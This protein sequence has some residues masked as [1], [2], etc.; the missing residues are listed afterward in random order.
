MVWKV[1]LFEDTRGE[2]PVFDFIKSLSKISIAKVTHMIDL[3]E[4]HGNLV[5]MPHSKQI[6]NNLYELRVRG[7]EEIR[8]FYTFK[9]SKIYLLHCFK[10]KTQKTP[11]KEIKIALS[12]LDLL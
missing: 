5:R 4:A 8:I 3:L 6:L 7:K 12:R 10:K 2:K 9:G 1:L 11:T